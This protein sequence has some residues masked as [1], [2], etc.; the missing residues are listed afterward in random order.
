M[1]NLWFLMVLIFSSCDSEKKIDS[2]IMSYINHFE[3][4]SPT[5]SGIFLVI[6][7]NSCGYCVKEVSILLSTDDLAHQIT[8]ITDIKDIVS[9][10]DLIIDQKQGRITQYNP[11]I[12][13]MYLFCLDFGK[14]KD[15]KE[16]NTHNIK[17]LK[18]IV[19]ELNE[20]CCTIM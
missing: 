18:N 11:F 14:V 8:V 4:V 9:K 2:Q 20:N 12:N 15:V 16:L 5:S 13:S 3:Q 17:N 1:R 10:R 19:N 7:S 6:P